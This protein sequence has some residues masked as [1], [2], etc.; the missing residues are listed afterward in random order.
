MNPES[1]HLIGRQSELERWSEVL[2]STE[3][4]TL[5]ITG[6]RGMGKSALIDRILVQT[7]QEIELHCGIVRYDVPAEESLE[8]TLRFLLEDAFYSARAKAGAFDNIGLKFWQWDAF[9]E[10][11]GF[12]G[13]KIET[14][15][16]LV[17]ALR[18]DPQK[19]IREQFLERLK[20]IAA[21]IPRQAR[22][23]LVFD[24]SDR[25]PE[26]SVFAWL[27]LTEKLPPFVKLVLTQ[28]DGNAFFHNP[29]F[30]EIPNL[31]AIP[32]DFEAGLG[33]LE[34]TDFSSLLT[35]PDLRSISFQGKL[36][37]LFSRYE[38]N[39]YLMNA[40]IDLLRSDPKLTLDDLPEEA[41][42]A[43][44]AQCQWERVKRFGEEAIRLFRAYSLLEI[45]APDEIVM[46]VAQLDLASFKQTLDIPYIR[47]LV[48]SRSGGHQ[49][50]DRPLAEC[51]ARDPDASPELLLEYHRRA[52]I[53]YQTMLERNLRPDPLC[54]SRIPLH[55]LACGG[56]NAY[57][58]SVGEMLDP[59]LVLCHFDSALQLVR[60]GL[61]MVESGS[62]E[63]GQLHYDAALIGLKR[64]DKA[65]AREN[66]LLARKILERT[67]DSETLADLYLTL[68]KI[69]A[70][71]G[72][73]AEA[74]ELLKHSHQRYREIDDPSGMVD[75]ATLLGEY[76]SYLDM[77]NQ[78]EGV[79]LG[80]IETCN[81]IEN[82]RQRSRS[83]ANVY[84]TLGRLYERRR[85][86]ERSTHQF[87]KAL[88][89]TRE[90]YDRDSEAVIY[91][92]LRDLLEETGGLK[93]AEEYQ[94]RS[95][96]IHQELRN[97][98][99]TALDYLNLSY[100]AQ[101]LENPVKAFQWLEEARQIFIQLG[102]EDKV[103]EI[104][105]MLEEETA[106]STKI[107][108]RLGSFLAVK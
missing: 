3:G 40:A 13:K 18:F 85:E 64:G 21:R 61:E 66:L 49:I 24:Y 79:L 47:K 88:D 100:L 6:G 75:S 106:P 11:I 9:F 15:Q 95:L 57:V 32:A 101:K 22:A 102:N 74:V 86:Y 67:G 30:A 4:Q 99:A 8:T 78:G 53:A 93:K 77:Q 28:P 71:G 45:T 104:E 73:Y 35:F 105:R 50:A 97:L 20:I 62:A 1:R 33:P 70:D 72:R 17:N 2:D 59:L 94:L 108:S 76:F 55:M 58:R 56:T 19:N 26:E 91:G 37:V 41:D 14:I 39:P 23:I 42:Y 65:V 54:A 84:C 10:R 34:K 96:K 69:E 82:N 48:Q 68:G 107:I 81:R 90:I 38:G 16:E 25:L 103:E 92:N 12:N 46:C 83:K 43:K 80:A 29:E 44:M 98:E 52:V 89:L 7:W 63:A 31:K 60:K 87:F 36:A 5:L 51:I 27:K